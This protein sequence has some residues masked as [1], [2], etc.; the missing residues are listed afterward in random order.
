MST[1]NIVALALFVFAW[2]F[3]EPL[4]TDLGTLSFGGMLKTRLEW[5]TMA[6]AGQGQFGFDANGRLLTAHGR[7]RVNWGL[8]RH[9]GVYA[10]YAFYYYELPA[11]T[12]GLSLL[13]HMAR[14]SV[15]S[16]CSSNFPC[17]LPASVSPSPVRS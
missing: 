6:S 5:L 14:Q 11:G 10:Q 13:P 17:D 15:D 3:Y 16:A 7:T 9:F 8:A 2:V 4:L 12:P 1:P